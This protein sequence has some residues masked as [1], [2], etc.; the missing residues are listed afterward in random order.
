VTEP[1]R[2]ADVQLKVRLF[3]IAL[4]L[5]QVPPVPPIIRLAV[6]DSVPPA[7]IPPLKVKVSVDVKLNTLLAVITT[8]PVF[9][10]LPTSVVV[11]DD[12]RNVNFEAKVAPPEV[13]VLLPIMVK[14][15][16]P[17]VTIVELRVTFP[18]TE[19]TWFVLKVS[20]PA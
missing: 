3:E 14:V 6:P 12:V 11:E 20:V 19:R 16:A 8:A 4:S 18:V 1:L 5:L 15:P 10:Q 17:V 7:F 9:I 13:R 2:V